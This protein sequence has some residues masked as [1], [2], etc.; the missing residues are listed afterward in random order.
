MIVLAVRSLLLADSAI[1]TVV[2]ERVYIDRNPQTD[3]APFI[4]LWNESERAL[5][6][7]D[8][9]LGMDQ[10]LVRVASYAKTRSGAMSLRMDVRRVLGGFNG[11]VSGYYIKG[12]AQEPRRGEFH[13]TDRVRVGTDQYR[14]VSVQDFRVTYDYA[15]VS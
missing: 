2:A 13:A 7:L 14:F 15:G 9:P 12:V 5:D 4:A 8:G 3:Q 1:S 11:V 6:A 10:P